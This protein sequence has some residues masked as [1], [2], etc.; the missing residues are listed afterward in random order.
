MT[1]KKTLSVHND[2]GWLVWFAF[3]IDGW[4][5]DVV[6]DKSA[7]QDA[8]TVFGTDA[9]V[10]LKSILMNQLH[11]QRA[12]GS[13]QQDAGKLIDTYIQKYLCN[14]TDIFGSS[15]SGEVTLTE[16]HEPIK[17][18]L[19]AIEMKNFQDFKDEMLLK[20]REEGDYKFS[21]TPTGGIGYSVEVTRLE[22]KDTKDITD[23]DCW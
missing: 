6:V 7:I 2:E 19:N 12:S 14:T 23:Y 15:W 21:F 20:Y 13:F 22:S 18:Q 5:C 11:R 16:E 9:L 8:Y 10:R 1:T 17:F 4:G 3:R